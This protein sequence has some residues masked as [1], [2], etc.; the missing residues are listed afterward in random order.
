MSHAQ[1]FKLEIASS[2]QPGGEDW[3][4]V[5][6]WAEGKVNT[7]LGALCVLFVWFGLFSS[8]LICFVTAIC[9]GVREIGDTEKLPCQ[10]ST[11]PCLGSCKAKRQDKLL[12]LYTK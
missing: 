2:S 12:F 8:A 1:Q 9:F 4:A 7:V 6:G 3:P 5:V 10:C 11:S